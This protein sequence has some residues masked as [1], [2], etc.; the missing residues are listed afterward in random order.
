SRVVSMTFMPFLGYYLLRPK[1][2]LSLE[3]RHR[4]GFAHYYY[5]FGRWS[6]RHRWLV[7][8]LS[9]LFLVG[10]GVMFT[11][12]E[13]QV[14]P[15]DLSYLS[16]IDVWLPEDATIVGTDET[17]TGVETVVREVAEEYGKKHPGKDGK[18]RNVLGRLTT[19]DGG[20]GPRFWFSVSPEVEQL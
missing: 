15:K 13:T 19:F 14:F 5:R 10:G 17:S 6:I 3:E 4:S 16:Y 12:L 11:E 8:A 18:P 7:A 9:L 20:G 2:E 1:A